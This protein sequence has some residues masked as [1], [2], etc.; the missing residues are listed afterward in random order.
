MK[1]LV[2]LYLLLIVVLTSFAGD[3]LKIMQYNL[4]YY[5]KITDWC[6]VWNNNVEDKNEYLKTITS[7]YKPDIFTVNEMNGSPA[8]TDKLLNNA[9]N[10]DGVGYYKRA[11]YT[12]SYIVNMLYYNSEKLALK[13][14]SYILTSPR[15]TDVYQLYYKSDN[16]QNT[17]TVF[18]T[19]IVTHLKAGNG[20]DEREARKTASEKIMRYIQNY[21]IKGN[22][23]LMGDLNVYY[24]S[25][26]AFQSFLQ[27]TSSGVQLVDPINRV[28]YWHDN[29][30]YAAY[31]TQSTHTSGG[32]HSGGGMDDRFDFILASKPIMEGSK[33]VTYVK[34]SYWAFGQDGNRLNESLIN[35]TNTTLP[36]EVIDA[37]YNMSDH[38][39]VVM[40]IYADTELLSSPKP[41]VNSSQIVGFTNPVS[42]ILTLDYRG[43]R[44]TNVE[45][46]LVSQTGSIMLN[47]PTHMVPNSTYHYNLQN[48][49]TGIYIL[50][51]AAK[52]F[53]FTDKI[54]KL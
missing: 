28:G 38:L 18:I 24:G 40:S 23:F 35:P 10:T 14:Q 21:N 1:K 7:F 37:L 49:S 45:V 42:N 26:P 6:T 12:G 41:E 2:S 19:C 52:N 48:F 8:S 32:C 39:P 13:S 11:N 54:V 34:D 33:G 17:D 43:D 51:V 4:L 25:E 53:T 5:D 29:E 27:P 30:S 44:N 22:I 47:K 31:H 3:S 50:K 9:L 46:S 15:I 16:L 20:S 36:T